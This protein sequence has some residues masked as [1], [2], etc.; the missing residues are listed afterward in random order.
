MNKSHTKFTLLISIFVMIFSF[1]ALAFFFK[2]IQNKNEHTSKVLTTLQQKI[3][4]KAKDSDLTKKISATEET[5]AKI[6]SYFVDSTQI[7]SFIGYLESLGTDAGT[8]VKVE[9]FDNPQATTGVL[10]VRLSASGTF[11]NVMRTILLLENSPY[12]IHITKTYLNRQGLATVTDAKG[13]SKATGV[14]N[15]RADISFSVLS[16]Q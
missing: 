14:P 10:Y 1:A 4:K 7:D 6:D 13:V 11:T 5:R 3:N 15:W 8:E 16:S 2:I 12:Q 9:G